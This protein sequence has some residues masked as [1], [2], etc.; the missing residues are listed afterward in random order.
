[1]SCRNWC[2]TLNNPQVIPL[3]LQITPQNKLKLVVYQLEEVSCQHLQGYLELTTPRRMS[4]VRKII[5]GAHWERRKGTKQ[6]AIEYCTKE[7]TRVQGP[8]ILPEGIPLSEVLSSVQE[9]EGSSLK[10]LKR[11]MDTGCSE[12]YIADEHF[13]HWVRHFRAF[14]AYRLL[15]TV[16]RN[17]AVTTT[18][19]VGPTGTGKSRFCLSK[20]PNAYW[21]QRS[22]WWDGYSGEETVVLDEFYGWIPYDTLLRLCDRYPLLVET[23]GGQSQ[24]VC[25]NV[26]ITSN[27]DPKSWYKNVYFD[28]FKRRVSKWVVFN[29]MGF[30]IDSDYGSFINR[31]SPGL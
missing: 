1:M 24:M 16:P 26:I 10:E 14:R 23:K 5:P 22:P 6:Q 9:S 18:V 12:E 31:L 11:M 20:Y 3:N 29:H 27:H 19:I 30:F 8:W 17:H 25:K 15:K 4:F 28:S 13:G 7:E 21:K 2:F